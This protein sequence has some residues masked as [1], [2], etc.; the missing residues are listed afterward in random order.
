ML[1]WIVLNG[2]HYL[3]KNGFGVKYKGWYD[4]KQHQTK[5][6]FNSAA[7][8]FNIEIHIFNIENHTFNIENH[9]LSNIKCTF[10]A[11][12]QNIIIEI[13]KVNVFLNQIRS[14]QE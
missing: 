14:L 4:I 2:S 6:N 3:H 10:L 13:L 12:L 9:N 1:N 11:L 7:K 8:Y 5:P